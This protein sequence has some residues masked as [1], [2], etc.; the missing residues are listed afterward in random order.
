MGTGPP[1]RLQHIHRTRRVD[2]K[3]AHR[4]GQGPGRPRHPSQMDH[5]IVPGHQHRSTN[6][7]SRTLPATSEASTPARFAPMPPG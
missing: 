5:R 7:T 1:G 4:I 2:T 3:R 6:P